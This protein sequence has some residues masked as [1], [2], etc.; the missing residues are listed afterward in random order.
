MHGALSVRAWLLMFFTALSMY[1]VCLSAELTVA[2]VGDQG[3]GDNAHGVLQLVAT[4]GPDLLLIQGDT[5]C[6]PKAAKQ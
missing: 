2:L 5:G 1:Q 6:H 3:A 4:E